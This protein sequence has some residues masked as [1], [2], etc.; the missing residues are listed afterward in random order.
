MFRAGL[1]ELLES[2]PDCRVIG[3]GASGE[4]AIALAEQ[5]QPDVLLLDVEMPGPEAHVT[6]PAVE[7]LSPRTRTV[8]LTMHDSPELA[9]RLLDAGA[10]GYVIKS[11]GREELLGAIA[12][13]RRLDDAVLVCASRHS[14]LSLGRAGSRRLATRAD[15]LSL[16]E[17]E[18]VRELASG[19]SNRD[20][21]AALAITEG[22]VKR[23]L[24]NIYAK[25]GASSRI[26]AVRKAAE[27]G[28]LR[29]PLVD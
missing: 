20:L 21:A 8:V 16:R 3:Q 19:G 9:S 26:D 5:C 22:T 27:R 11:A 24:A 17:S 29:A 4:D 25:L 28:I 12:A 18:V 13:A 15:V 6:I 1:I 10:V 2:M 7:K 23:H 14:L